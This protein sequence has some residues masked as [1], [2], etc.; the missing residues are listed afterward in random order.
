M[1]PSEP[2]EISREMIAAGL[3]ALHDA[4]TDCLPDAQMVKEVFW[5]MYGIGH[6]CEPETWH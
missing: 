3:E 2:P 4:R 6:Y 5:A 1:I